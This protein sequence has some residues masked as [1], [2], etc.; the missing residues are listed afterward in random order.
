MAKE[1]LLVTESITTKYRPKKLEHLIGQEHV[2]TVLRGMIKTKSFPPVFLISGN[3]GVGKTTLS[4]II[5]RYINCDTLNA[6]GECDSCK[7][8]SHPDLLECNIGDTRG[9]DDVRSIVQSSKISPRF[10]KR[11]L[12]LDECF[13]A[14]TEVEVDWGVFKT[15]HEICNNV[16]ID[17]VLSY[18]ADTNSIE[19][20]PIISKTPKESDDIVRVYLE[21]GSYQDCTSNH[22]WWSVTRN[23]MVR[24]DELEEG[25]ELLRNA[26]HKIIKVESVSKIPSTVINVYDIGVH[27]N[28]NFFIRPKGSA[29]S[30]LVS[31]CHQ[32]T[33][34]AANCILKSLE[35]PSKNTLF[36]LATTNPEKVLT[37]IVGR[38]FRLELVPIPAKAMIKRL[39]LIAKEEGV[40]FA[41]FESGKETLTLLASLCNGQFR[42]ALQMLESLLFA[43]KSGEKIT[44]KELL[45]KFTS[46]YSVDISKLSA[47][48]LHALLSHNLRD[49][50]HYIVDNPDSRALMTKMRW[51][52]Q[53]LF[54][55]YV[56]K[57]PQ[58]TT[59]EARYFDGLCKAKP[60]KIN[61]SELLI[62]QA[63]LVNTEILLNSSPID[64]K[65]LLQSAIGNYIQ[66]IN[67]D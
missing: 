48:T 56:G 33:S 61:Y 32:L 6:C 45:K 13:P 64:P 47:K 16:S 50:L 3:S 49:T 22:K 41:D 18:N 5:N 31:N 30:V 60:I 40:D 28:H 62:L 43:I 52:I 24:A 29:S 8:I 12:L 63:A 55:S 44:P 19:K 2:S 23:K 38:C 39:Y 36:I 11:I 27:Q 1:T 57:A 67:N 14:D 37:P 46:T 53:T 15:V 26:Q 20:M 9:I 66:G 17:Q 4:R 21:D 51:L 34:Q 42:D 59:Y 10:N 58:Y 35:E 25:E 7:R 65:I 54:L